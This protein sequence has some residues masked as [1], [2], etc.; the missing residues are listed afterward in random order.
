MHTYILQQIG[1]RVCPCVRS[2]WAIGLPVICGVSRWIRGFS[3]GLRGL[4]Y[5]IVSHACVLTIT[6]S[7]K[8]STSA[9][10]PSL[11]IPTITSV[12]TITNSSVITIT[13]MQVL[14]ITNSDKYRHRLNG[15]LALQG[16][17]TFQASP[18]AMPCPPPTRYLVSY[19]RASVPF[20]DVAVEPTN[21]KPPARV[22]APAPRVPAYGSIV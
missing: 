4:R 5:N 21:R 13:K 6:N 2:H 12:L 11:I 18:S 9:F 1:K 7:D 14:T 8:Y 15:H 20:R 16:T 19:F 22:P 10:L 3:R 17:H